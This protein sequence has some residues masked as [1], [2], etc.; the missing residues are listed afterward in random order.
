MQSGPFPFPDEHFDGLI[1]CHVFEHFDAQL[2]LRV[3]QECRRILR[4]G[5]VLLVSVPNAS[6]FREVYHH[7]RNEN[8][9]ELFDVTDPANPIPTFFEAALWFDQH[10][11]IFTQD[12]LWCFLKRAGFDTSSPAKPDVIDAMQ[13]LLNRRKFSVELF[14]VKP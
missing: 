1:F 8:W 3:M 2:G 4:S 11:M 13:P 12:A 14:G 7:D 5:G 9:P 10:R 6:Y